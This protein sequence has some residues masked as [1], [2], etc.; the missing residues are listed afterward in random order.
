MLAS[1]AS[2]TSFHIPFLRKSGTR[3]NLTKQCIN[4]SLLHTP[5]SVTF[6]IFDNNTK[7]VFDPTLK[8]ERIT[9]GLL[10]ISANK[11]G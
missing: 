5:L 1:L 11:F 8:E 4:L 6:A 10:I 2:W 3:I 7:Y 9:D